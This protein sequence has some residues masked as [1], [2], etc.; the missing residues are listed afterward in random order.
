VPW[1]ARRQANLAEILAVFLALSLSDGIDAS[2]LD[3]G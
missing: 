1:Q 2:R 3:F